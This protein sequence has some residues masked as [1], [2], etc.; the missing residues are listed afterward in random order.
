MIEGASMSIA[1]TNLTPF[2]YDLVVAVT[3]KSLNATMKVFLDSLTAPEVI[4]C[5]IYNNS[6]TMVPIGYEALKQA[7]HGSD[8]FSVPD[9]ADP[10]TNQDLINL[11][12]ASFAGAFKA[13]IG[14]PDMNDPTKIPPVVTLQGGAGAPVIFNLLCAEFN[15]VG[16]QYMGPISIWLNKAQATDDPWYF[17]ATVNIAKATVPPGPTLPAAVQAKINS[18]EAGTFGVQ[19][20]F[21]DLDTAIKGARNPTFKGVDPLSALATLVNQVFLGAYFKQMRESGQPVLGYSVTLNTPDPSSLQLGAVVREVCPLLDASGNPIVNPTPAQQDAATFDYLCTIS[22]TSPT[23]QTFP[24][25][26]VELGEV[27]SFSGTQAVRRDTFA[28]VLDA[29][30]GASLNANFCMNPDIAW[31]KVGGNGPGYAWYPSFN[32]TGPCIFAPAAVSVPVNPDDFTLLR[33][34]TWYPPLQQQATPW[35]WDTSNLIW[36]RYQVTAQYVLNGWV[37]LSMKGGVPTL[38]IKLN[39]VLNFGA[40]HW[41]ISHLTNY[42]NVPYVQYINLEVTL[43]LTLTVTPEGR[44]TVELPQ[45]MPTPTDTSQPFEFWQTGL[46]GYWYGQMVAPTMRSV[47]Q[48]TKANLNNNLTNLAVVV[49]GG[50]DGSQGWVFPGGK[51]FTFKQVAFSDYLDLISRITY[52]DPSEPEPSIIATKP[53][54]DET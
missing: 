31:T 7:A 4:A 32:S 21:L 16:F 37:S 48:N 9:G 5:F 10:K 40:N 11:A 33:Y 23:P 2:G 42:N 14:L 27:S 38:R 12:K 45:T 28:T 29:A 30:L 35:V 22:T 25:N 1:Q 13:Q 51:S 49:K 50:L 34:I 8:P 36:I 24:W 15:I 52:A 41:E 18:L 43:D 54:S 39:T 20:I 44:L 47:I 53:G 6:G 3:Q 26:W 46:G 19:Q 17:N